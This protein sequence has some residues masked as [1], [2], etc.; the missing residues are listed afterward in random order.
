MN[1]MIIIFL[2]NSTP[3][4]FHIYY[5]NCEPSVVITISFKSFFLSRFDISSL[6]KAC[7]PSPSSPTH[8]AERVIVLRVFKVF[9]SFNVFQIKIQ[10]LCVGVGNTATIIMEIRR[11]TKTRPNSNQ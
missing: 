6:L 4:C 2:L 10:K 3:I 7:C 9:N 8:M 1:D 11:N 5:N